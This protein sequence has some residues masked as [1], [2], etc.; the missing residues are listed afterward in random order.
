MCRYWDTFLHLVNLL[1]FLVAADRNG[2]WDSHLQ[3]IQNLLPVFRE[4]DSINYLRYASWYLEKM[5]CLEEKHPEVYHKFKAGNFVVRQ[6]KR[7]F[8]AVSPDLKLEQT[9]QRSQKSSNGIIGQTRQQMYVTEYELVY[10]EVLGISNRFREILGA[11]SSGYSE[12]IVHHELSG[13]LNAN[14]LKHINILF[15]FMNTRGNPY[16]SS[17]Q[18]LLHNFI[19][20]KCVPREDAVRLLKVKEHGSEAY[21]PFRNDRFV[22]KTLKLSDVI[23]KIRLPT[24]E[25]KIIIPTVKSQT[26]QAT[27]KKEYCCS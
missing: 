6:T 16:E 21:E 4:F 26:A 24:M 20:S 23:R 8:T 7:P 22:N 15:E 11:D 27:Q 10:H 17:I 3:A 2:D 18:T 5:R 12:V 19:N 25:R 13:N 14:M 1:K 9:I